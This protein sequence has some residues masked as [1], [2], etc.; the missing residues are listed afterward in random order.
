MQKPWAAMIMV[1]SLGA[2]GMAWAD[3]DCHVPFD[4]WLAPGAVVEMAK[5]RGWEVDKLEI[6]D[7]CYEIRGR[8]QQGQA[9]KAKI[10]PESLQLIKWKL[11]KRHRR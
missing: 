11:A 3:D 7:G 9:F 6:D 2:A 8:D 1:L 5:E 4:R 10:D